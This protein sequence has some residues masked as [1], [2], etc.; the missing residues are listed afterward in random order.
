MN[1][2]TIIV[3]VLMLAAGAFIVALE[4]NSRRNQRQ[5]P[6]GAAEPAPEVP[7]KQAVRR[8]SS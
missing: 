1:L 5:R 3:V 4:M 6:N 7:P 2:G 8:R